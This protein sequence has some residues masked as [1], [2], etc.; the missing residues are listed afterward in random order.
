MVGTIYLIS[1][2]EVYVINNHLLKRIFTFIYIFK[3]TRQM[4]NK[5]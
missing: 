3:I 1:R 2:N 4:F 5:N